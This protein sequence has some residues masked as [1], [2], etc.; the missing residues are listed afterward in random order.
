VLKDRLGRLSATIKKD[1]LTA[2]ATGQARY[3]AHITFDAKPTVEIAP[4][5]EG[6]AG[7]VGGGSAAGPKEDAA[8]EEEEKKE[9]KK[10]GFGIGNIASSLTTGRQ[11]ESTQASASAG[12]RMA[13]PD[14]NAPGGANRTPVRVTISA[15]ELEEFRKG[16]A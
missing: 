4:V 10:K 12:G 3:A 5:V 9:P 8:K 14:T 13:T 6:A 16:I 11:A 15:A 7:A 1:K 2:S